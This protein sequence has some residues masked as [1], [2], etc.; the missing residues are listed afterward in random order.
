MLRSEYRRCIMRDYASREHGMLLTLDRFSAVQF[1]KM[2][3]N[4][5]LTFDRLPKTERC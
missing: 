5:G 4:L 2:V 3:P 1:P